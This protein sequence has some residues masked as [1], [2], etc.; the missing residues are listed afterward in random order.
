MRCKSFIIIELKLNYPGLKSVC[1]L[2]ILQIELEPVGWIFSC[3]FIH[4]IIGQTLGDQLWQNVV[5]N[6]TESMTTEPDLE[7]KISN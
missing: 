1:N 7:V 6:V 2:D 3:D 5:Q 4:L